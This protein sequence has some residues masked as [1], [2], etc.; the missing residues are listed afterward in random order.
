MKY[1]LISEKP[2]LMRA[3]QSAFFKAHMNFEVDF[4]SLH[5]HCCTLK[6]PGDYKEEWKTWNLDTL[7]MIPEKFEHV[8]V[9]GKLVAEI[10]KQLSST[11]YDGFINCT[12]AEREGQ[13]IFYSLYDYLG[14]NLPV[15]RFWASDLT[16]EKL[17]DAWKHLK[18]DQHDT[19]LKNLT[20]A[21]LL[22]AQADW[23]VGMNFSR[24]VS[25]T[26]GKSIPVGRVMTVVLAML[27]KREEEIK[28]FKPVTT[29]DVMVDY[30][31]GFSGKLKHDPY[32]KKEDAQA[33]VDGIGNTAIIQEFETKEKV[34]EAPL[35]YSLGDLQN[36][37]NKS[38][39]YSLA[40]SLAIIQG[41]YEKKILSYPRTD[42]PYL[43]SGEGARM[44]YILAAARCIPE[45]LDYEVDEKKVSGYAKSKY[46]NDKKV[47]AHYAIVF[48]GREFKFE[49]L[50]DKEK[51]IVTLVAKRIVATL[52][53]P[54]KTTEVSVTAKEKDNI[55]VTKE[56]VLTYAGWKK[57]Y[58]DEEKSVSIKG[59]KNGQQLVITKAYVKDVVSTCPKRFN[60]ASINK[61]MI[62]VG[63]LIEDKELASALEGKT[64]DQGGIGT[65]ATRAGI[66][67]KLLD[68]SKDWVSRKNKSFYVSDKGINVYHALMNYS[69]SSPILTAE[70]EKK[71]KSVEDGE[72]DPNTF[73][74]EL[75]KYINDECNKLKTVKVEGSLRCPACGEPLKESDKYFYCS[76]YKNPC[77]FIIGKKT[78]GATITE[79]DVRQLIE[80][81]KTGVKKFTSK[82]GKK[83]EACLKFAEGK[84]SYEF[85]SSG[86]SAG[87]AETNIVCSCG[88]AIKYLNGK[89]GKYY[90]CECGKTVSELTFGHKF[91]KAE[92]KKLFAG[93]IVL[94]EKLKGKSGKEFA[95]NLKIEE[96]KV[97]IDSFERRQ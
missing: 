80:K 37:A 56:S 92:I 19:Y 47:Q 65:P 77:T 87:G 88:N 46:V 40:D 12:D 26:N 32:E 78:G 79:S 30:K 97:K 2:S 44:A 29:Y 31:E 63:T 57:L 15:K 72:K 81:G 10:Q 39:G 70:W 7:P 38:Y 42:C 93:E 28:N 82:E 52:M 89:F 51:N 69:V 68:P 6:S 43:T 45:I 53:D 76:K 91:S 85:A 17:I 1:L 11:K 74:E 27:A 73:S 21:A 22:R 61:A 58:G 64:K 54:A 24:M 4:M 59:L 48:T 75:N 90:K 96:N 23:L 9:D 14:S 60:D 13:N 71:L 33:I 25:I 35:L 62:N 86:S 5:G 18:D 94:V 8:P 20:D 3:V 36:D 66:V 84:V 16:D 49:D 34:S 67:E 41:L 55:F 95:A 50:S 83:F